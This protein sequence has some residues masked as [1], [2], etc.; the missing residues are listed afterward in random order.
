M[1]IYVSVVAD[2]LDIAPK[3]EQEAV[4]VFSHAA[5]MYI[6]CAFDDIDCQF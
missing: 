2:F 1:I 6:L 5:N 4:P 3:I